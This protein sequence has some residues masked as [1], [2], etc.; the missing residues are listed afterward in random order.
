MQEASELGS[1]HVACSRFRF[2][3]TH[4]WHA[5]GFGFGQHPMAC[6]RFWVWAAPMW[7]ARGFRFRQHPCGMPEDV[8]CKSLQILAA[9]TWHAKGFGFGQHPRGMPEVS[10]LDSTH[11]ACQRFRVRAR[12]SYRGGQ[13]PGQKFRMQP[14]S[15]ES[16]PGGV[17]SAGPRE[18]G[19]MS[20]GAWTLTGTTR[21][22]VL[23]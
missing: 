19:I 1:T 9:P 12:P 2:W 23:G 21:A 17:W 18:L 4:T 16:S 22:K 8:A 20:E 13:N 5:R 6:Q 7:H 14:R 11:V 10:G 15:S 3:A